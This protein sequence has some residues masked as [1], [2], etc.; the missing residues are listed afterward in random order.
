MS[1]LRLPPGR[2]AGADNHVVDGGR[3]VPFCPVVAKCRLTG[4]DVS[5]DRTATN[6]VELESLAVAYT[7]GEQFEWLEGKEMLRLDAERAVEL[8]AEP[9]EIQLIRPPD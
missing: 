9:L 1:P 2:P 5:R 6:L 4:G 7:V 8:M 3:G